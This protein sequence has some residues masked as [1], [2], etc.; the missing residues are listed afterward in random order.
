M[1]SCNVASENTGGRFSC[2]RED[3]H[4]GPCAAVQNSPER[5]LKW[6]SLLV[7][8]NC[9]A[10]PLLVLSEVFMALGFTSVA[11]NIDLFHD[12]TIPDDFTRKN[13]VRRM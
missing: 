9:I 12:A 2:T 8:H 13:L 3:G 7:V 6:W 5:T 1:K 11:Y 4:E 10:H